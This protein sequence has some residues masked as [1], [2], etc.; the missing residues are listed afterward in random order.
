[1]GHGGRQL[2]DGA[3]ARLLNQEILG[4]DEV[5]VQ[6]LQ[7]LHVE[8]PLHGN[9]KM[10][11]ECPQETIVEQVVWQRLLTAVR[12]QAQGTDGLPST[13]QQ[14]PAGEQDAPQMSKITRGNAIA[15]G[16]IPSG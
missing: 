14:G 9:P 13:S 3:H 11:H 15:P 7:P 6:S 1:M 12:A 16:G 8:G 5:A 4:P 2:P 10:A